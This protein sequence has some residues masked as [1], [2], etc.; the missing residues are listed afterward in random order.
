MRSVIQRVK[1][2]SVCVE[3]RVIASIT[4]GLVV[5]LGVCHDDDSSR[6]H[7]MADKVTSLRIFPN[8][9]G[10]MNKSVSQV[11]GGLLIVSQFTLY[12]NTIKGRRPSFTEAAVRE[13]AEPLYNEFVNVCRQSISLVE[14]GWFGRD[15]DVTLVNW[16][17]VTIWLDSDMRNPSHHSD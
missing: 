10:K 2:A 9:Q 13:T 12:A 8:E 11:A 3:N 5:F 6:V 4:Q 7:W 1:R 14:T 17:P 15:M 16:G